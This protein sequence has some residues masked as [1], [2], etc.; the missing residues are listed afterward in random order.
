MD[1]QWISAGDFARKFG[2]SRQKAHRAL[3]RAHDG[4]PWRGQKLRVR[5]SR[6]QGGP[7][8]LRYEVAL[9]DPESSD[10]SKG[11]LPA[12]KHCGLRKRGNG[13]FRPCFDPYKKSKWGSKKLLFLLKNRNSHSKKR[14]L[15]GSGGV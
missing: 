8:G 9:S 1:D 5:L 3:S 10:D 6:S 14:F 12:T 7:E 13:I 15:I 11:G 2:I 4:H